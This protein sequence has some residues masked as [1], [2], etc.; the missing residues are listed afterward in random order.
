M[1]C[2]YEPDFICRHGPRDHGELRQT[3]RQFGITPCGKLCAVD[4][5]VGV[6]CQQPTPPGNGLRRIRM[7]TGQHDGADAC[8]VQL[9][10]GFRRFRPHRVAQDNEC[11]QR[12]TGRNVVGGHCAV[13]CRHGNDTPTFCGLFAQ[14]AQWN[15][16]RQAVYPAVR[17]E[18]LRAARQQNLRRA[19]H[20]RQCLRRQ[21][22]RRIFAAGIKWN[23]IPGLFRRLSCRQRQH[24]AQQ[25]AVSCIAAGDS[26]CGECSTG[27]AAAVGKNP[28][29]QRGRARAHGRNAVKPCSVTRK[30][31]V[32][33]HAPAGQ[34]AGLVGEQNI[35]T[36]C[37]LNARQAAHQHM[38]AQ[39]AHHVGRQHDRNHHRQAFRHSDDQYGD[40]QC[41][42][43]QNVLE[44]RCRALHQPALYKQ[45]QREVGCRDKDGG[46]HAQLADGTRKCLQPHM[47]RAFARVLLH[48]PRHTA[49]HRFAA[50]GGDLHHALAG[51]D[52][53]AAE[54]Q[55]GLIGSGV[56]RLRSF[57]DFMA[58]AGQ[59]GLVNLE[60]AL[61]QKAIRRDALTCL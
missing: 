43:V 41:D 47:Q 8:C 33:C 14:D 2:L 13:C 27:V 50:D 48:L 40:C 19:A 17:G 18:I 10:D 61:A 46:A 57:A 26:A 59:C 7:V 4:D 32:R 23:L 49:V 31:H 30:H 53:A 51:H 60:T 24:C 22:H 11:G 9:A 38:V 6:R 12:Q 36:A 1:G 29:V 5:K 34:R 37:G 15:V 54:Q 45:R 28:A 58:L 20:Q 25:G 3:L 16:A 44:N 21:A 56:F 39:H 42:R 35:H 55:S 52:N